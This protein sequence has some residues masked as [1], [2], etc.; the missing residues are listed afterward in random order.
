MPFLDPGPHMLRGARAVIGSGE[1]T[2]LWEDHG[3]QKS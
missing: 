1:N 3:L 2:L